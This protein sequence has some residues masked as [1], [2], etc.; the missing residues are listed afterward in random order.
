[1]QTALFSEQTF[2]DI[3]QEI[4]EVKHAVIFDSFKP[5]FKPEV[6]NRQC[7][8][9]FQS[10]RNTSRIKHVKTLSQVEVFPIRVPSQIGQALTL[11]LALPLSDG[12][13]Y[14]FMSLF[15]HSVSASIRVRG[16]ATAAK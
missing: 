12:F 11:M 5:E 8:T 16:N 6:N 4:I 1:M 13:L 2:N 3:M 10:G 7:V 14:V 9:I 15:G